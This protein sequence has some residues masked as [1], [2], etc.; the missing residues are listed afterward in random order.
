MPSSISSV[1]SVA[2]I[3]REGGEIFFLRKGKLRM[4]LKEVEDTILLQVGIDPKIIP[5]VQ[6]EINKLFL[7]QIAL[8]A[9]CRAADFISELQK[10]VR[11]G[12]RA[13]GLDM[14]INIPAS[15]KQY[16]LQNF[17]FFY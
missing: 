7:E 14:R 8:G 3:E 6:V 10:K 17:F 12:L 13:K 4:T 11:D 5:I 16:L 2:S 15:L 1:S 9:F